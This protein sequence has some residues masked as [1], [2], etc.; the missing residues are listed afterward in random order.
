MSIYEYYF[1]ERKNQGRKADK[2]LVSEKTWVYV[3]KPRLAQLFFLPALAAATRG[4]G[5]WQTA[6]FATNAERLT[7]H[8]ADKKARSQGIYV[9][10]YELFLLWLQVKI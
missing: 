8:V 10:F 3:Q 4:G 2:K 9:S 7:L 1:V 6:P 5:G